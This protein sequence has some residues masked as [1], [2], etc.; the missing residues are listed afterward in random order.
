[1]LYRVMSVTAIQKYKTKEILVDNLPANPLDC[2][3]T[4]GT[5]L[6]S[7]ILDSIASKN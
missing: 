6:L 4:D 5:E 2:H 3:M 1:M 7:T